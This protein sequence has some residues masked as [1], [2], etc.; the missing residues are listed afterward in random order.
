MDHYAVL[1]TF[2]TVCEHPSFS[3]AAAALN[4]DRSLVSKR[5]QELESALGVRLFHRNSRRMTPTAEGLARLDEAKR[6]LA[7]VDRFFAG[8]SDSFSFRM[9][10]S[11]AFSEFFLAEAVERYL[12]SHP[13][14]QIELVACEARPDLAGRNIDVWFQVGGTTELED[15]A[16]K[17]GESHGILCASADYLSTCGAVRTPGDL[18]RCRMLSNQAIG[19]RWILRSVSE[20][21]AKPLALH[22]EAPLLYGNA[23]QAMHGA[24]RGNGI[25]LLPF[26]I[27]SPLLKDGRLVRV[28]S[29]WQSVVKPIYAV[30][31]P[32]MR[33]NA[34]L[35]EF[36]NFI[37]SVMKP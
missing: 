12:A 37:R 10:S 21:E 23:I 36:M 8:R 4:V 17:I 24:E 6:L 19:R 31:E 3:S 34:G 35:S 32:G 25:A 1:R 15:E 11:S 13:N 18:L 30:I 22:L 2:V 20:P 7:D 16:L 33:D 14:V 5:M 28:L 27:A 26:A 9:A 29:D